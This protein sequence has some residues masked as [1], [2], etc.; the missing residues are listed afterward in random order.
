MRRETLSA[1]KD[2]IQHI[3]DIKYLVSN[4]S[5]A[6]SKLFIQSIEVVELQVKKQSDMNSYMLM[7]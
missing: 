1:L 7:S 4:M 2:D 6:A 5:A 3:E